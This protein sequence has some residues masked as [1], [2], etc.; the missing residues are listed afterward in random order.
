MP[1]AF[2][3]SV[4]RGLLLSFLRFGVRVTLETESKIATKDSVLGEDVSEA[5]LGVDDD[6]KGAIQSWLPGPPKADP[7]AQEKIPAAWTVSRSSAIVIWLED[8]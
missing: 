1:H 3:S 2:L 8:G 6:S 5:V 7:D 4:S